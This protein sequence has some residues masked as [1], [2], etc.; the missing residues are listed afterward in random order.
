MSIKVWKVNSLDTSAEQTVKVQPT[1]EFDGIQI[2]FAE[3]DGSEDSG[4]L[5]ILSNE[6]PELIERLQSMM[7]YVTKK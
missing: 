6:L 5:Y 7:D 4:K 3:L 2:S 1:P